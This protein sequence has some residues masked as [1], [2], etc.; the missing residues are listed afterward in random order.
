MY[1]EESNPRLD[2][3]IN[4]VENV[5]DRHIVTTTTTK[6]LGHDYVPL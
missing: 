3:M 5:E 4:D 1:E 2:Y 6:S